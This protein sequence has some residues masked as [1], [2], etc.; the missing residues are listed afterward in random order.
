MA[1]SDRG[2]SHVT[3]LELVIDQLTLYSTHDVRDYGAAV[4]LRPRGRRSGGF[5]LAS[6][7]SNLELTLTI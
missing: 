4:L 3:S 7:P 1:G 2:H 5:G 6:G